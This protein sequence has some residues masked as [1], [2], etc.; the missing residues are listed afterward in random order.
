MQPPTDNHS[1]SKTVLKHTNVN[2]V[3]FDE[4]KKFLIHHLSGV[5]TYLVKNLD[6]IRNEPAKL[7]TFKLYLS[8]ND[9]C[10]RELTGF[11]NGFIRIPSYI[12]D[13]SYEQSIKNACYFA[14]LH[15]NLKKLEKETPLS[16]LLLTFSQKIFEHGFIHND[17][18]FRKNVMIRFENGCFDSQVNIWH[19]DSCNIDQL[20]TAISTS[21][22]SISQWGTRL[23]ERE[24]TKMFLKHILY[25]FLQDSNE[26][27]EEIES[28]S[29]IGIP[30]YLY[31]VTKL[32]HR[33][34]RINEL[35]RKITPD[36]YR[37]FIRFNTKSPSLY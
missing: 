6:L 19:M 7:S 25:G 3:M 15:F 31:N 16:I 12:L 11:K 21:Y 36:D 18:T 10:C 35:P 29:T 8:S 14:E 20:Y 9:E 32:L 1:Y 27:I 2:S 30:G 26:I 17:S 5:Y 13:Q 34:P 37:F 22:S 28:L 23:L 24:H 33:A 4:A